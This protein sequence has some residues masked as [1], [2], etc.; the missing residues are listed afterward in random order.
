MSLRSQI[1]FAALVCT[2]AASAQVI[3][4]GVLDSFQV[5]YAASLTNGDAY[6]DITNNGASIPAGNNGNLC[7]NAYAFDASEEMLACCACSVTPNGLVSMSVLHSLVANPFGNA[8]VFGSKVSSLRPMISPV[9]TPPPPSIVVKL[10]AT[11]NQGA[12]CSAV[13]ITAAELAPGMRA[14]GTTLHSTPAGL[15]IAETPFGV[16]QLS[17]AELAHLTSFCAFITPSQTSPGL[18]GYGICGGCTTGGL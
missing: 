3:N 6:V 9:T 4:N 18:S 13:N 2:V 10:V 11:S 17:A 12:A 16:S 7:V 15:Q 14:W 1:V 5:R 8:T